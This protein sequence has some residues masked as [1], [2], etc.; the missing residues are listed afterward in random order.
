MD[1]EP[2]DTGRIYTVTQVLAALTT[3]PN[4]FMSLLASSLSKVELLKLEMG[5]A[6]TAAMTPM[7]VE[8]FRHT[9]ASTG[10][11]TAG[12]ALTPVN[13]RGHA[14]APASTSVV[15]AASTVPHSTAQAA[16]FHADTFEFDSGKFSWCPPFPETLDIAQR[17]HVRLTGL[18]TASL[19][20]IVGTLTYRETGKIPV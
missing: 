18:T 11:S 19:N 8:L 2:L 13:I 10:G 9:S 15:V 12:G 16:R 14:N 4:E 1:R 20:G 6:S 7:T 5:Q 3:A 17:F